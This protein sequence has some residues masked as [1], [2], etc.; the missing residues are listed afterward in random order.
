MTVDVILM[1]YA[2]LSEEER[3]NVTVDVTHDDDEHTWD[4]EYGLRYGCEHCP[5][6]CI[7]LTD[8]PRR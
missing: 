1:M 2:L 6:H 3:Y 4:S 5:Q 8:L 7:Q